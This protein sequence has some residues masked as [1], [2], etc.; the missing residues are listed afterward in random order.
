[1]KFRECSTRT[2]LALAVCQLLLACAQPAKNSFVSHFGTGGEAEKNYSFASDEH[3]K[4]E[5]PDDRKEAKPRIMLGDGSIL[6][7]PAAM[8][9][10]TGQPV[11]L[12]FEDAPLS[13]VVRTIL[14]DL[15]A[16]DFVLHPPIGGTVTLNT[17]QPVPA[18]QALNLLE[19]A[20]QANGMAMVRDSRG[21]YHVGKVEALRSLGAS[22]RQVGGG[23]T[24]AP[25]FGAIIV[26]LQY[27]GANE[28]AT[29]LRPMVPEGAILRVDTIRNLLVLSGT[30]AQAEGWLDMVRTFDVN[31]L[32]GMSVGIFPLKYVTIQE[33]SSALQLLNGG[34]PSAASSSGSVPGR[35]AVAT[36]GATASTT[37]APSNAQAAVQ[38]EG[39]PL[40]GALRILP[41]E[42]LNSILI[43]TPRADYLQEAQRWIA[44]LD[45]PGAGGTQ[46]RLNIYRVQNGNAK[47]LASVLGGI[48]GGVAANAGTR[49]NSGVAPG[50]GTSVTSTGLGVGA[51]F[52]SGL[53][54]S[55]SGS[56]GFG[57]G[58]SFG[59]QG[60]QGNG[61]AQVQPGVSNV[62]VVDGVRVMADE[63]NNSV[64]IWGTPAEYER[65]EAALKRLDVPPTQVLIEASIIEVTLNDELKYGLQWAFNGGVG[66]RGHTG[67]GQ[68]TQSK[69]N[70]PDALG[71][72]TSGFSYA[73]SSSAGNIRAVLNALS[74]KTNLKVVASPSLMVLDNH[75]AAIA[76]GTQQ[77]YQS[78]QIRSA[79]G[80][81]TTTSIQYKDT[82]VNLQVTPSVN[83]GNIVTMTV[84]QSVTDVGDVDEPSGQRSFLQRQVSS[85]VAVRSG[86]S[87]VMGGLIQ[88]NSSQGRNGIP[89]LHEI[90][91]VGNLFGSTNNRT[92]RTELVVV[93]TPRVVRN[94]LDIRSVTD[95]LRSQMASLRGLLKVDTP[96]QPERSPNAAPTPGPASS[97]PPAAAAPE[98]VQPSVP[99]VV[100]PSAAPA[101]AV[102]KPAEPAAPVAAPA[103]SSE[104]AKTDEPL[105]P[106]AH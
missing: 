30:R 36:P 24:L 62:T 57:A 41:L 88:E 95:S 106:D 25:G 33:V 35:P 99:A 15:L 3:D 13:Q 49:A 28:M 55:A 45:Q 104:P 60:Q 97:L 37:A 10:V 81:S 52:G 77:P 80:G 50:L 91:V 8:P 38:S 66:G 5:K 94:D 11:K 27:I 51:G 85:R 40:L 89:V 43:V 19:T 71:A 20:L 87:I 18:D 23:N 72:I 90:P 84:N 102:R 32:K 6:G 29:I 82:G 47:H 65:I 9:A 74:S 103:S 46:P 70:L 42:R 96:P 2:V 17:Q 61:Q 73:I 93:I 75:T 56:G 54:S 16:Q 98:G 58:Q 76:V 48:F 4:A 105:A 101:P 12:T 67:T 79:E 64:L 68:L 92:A 26:P 31:L 22:V 83:A 14:G 59:L 53:G 78:A 69:G 34:A 44:K 100:Q 1:M 7:K 63:L 39:N 21:T 86:E